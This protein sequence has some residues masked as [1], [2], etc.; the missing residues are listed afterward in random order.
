LSR[1][2]LSLWSVFG[3]STSPPESTPPPAS[4]P[5][6]APTP[7][8]SPSLD[9][10]PSA[11]DKL[12]ESLKKAE[13][14]RRA[15]S[16]ATQK[17]T[18][19]QLL[20]WGEWDPVSESTSPPFQDPLG[21]LTFAEQVAYLANPPDEYLRTLE[22]RAKLREEYERELFTADPI[23]NWK[24][25]YDVKPAWDGPALPEWKAW[26]QDK[27]LEIMEKYRRYDERFQR[28]VQEI[29]EFFTGDEHLKRMG[30]QTTF[31]IQKEIRAATAK[32]RSKGKQK[33]PPPIME[34]PPLKVIER[35]VHR[36]VI[37]QR[38]DA[39]N[40]L[41]Y[42][43]QLEVNIFDDLNEEGLTLTEAR[44][45]KLPEVLEQKRAEEEKQRKAMKD[46][47]T[48]PSDVKAESIDWR[49]IHGEL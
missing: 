48:L 7:L 3:K 40:R 4:S 24:L 37:K 27:R 46:W 17:E 34:E 44:R 30:R 35:K 9:Q 21:H 22:G 20:A 36:I 45:K 33:E 16:L 25:V 47:G 29:F 49:T 23:N 2:Q 38:N 13:E 43:H 19:H 15:Q 10:N 5:S 1:R 14:R 28:K 12:T 42:Q 8:Q 31:K 32:K 18:D 26:S 6:T 11:E 41:W 39:L